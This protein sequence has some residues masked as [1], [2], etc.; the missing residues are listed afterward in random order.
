CLVI[1]DHSYEGASSTHICNV[2]GHIAGPPDDSLLT[3]DGNDGRGCLW[4]NA[5][6]IAIDE[7]I[8]HKIPDAEYCLLRNS[9]K[10][11]IEV[12]HELSIGRFHWRNFIGKDQGRR[13]S[14]K[15][16]GLPPPQGE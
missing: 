3:S 4:R 1:A 8:K 13:E 9:P 5:R 7:I 10:R 2:T 15:R 11:L 14:A 6:N 12:E 16:N